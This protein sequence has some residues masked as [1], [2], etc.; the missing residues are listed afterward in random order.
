MSGVDAMARR[1]FR[2]HPFAS[3]EFPFD[4]A[5]RGY[6]V[7]TTILQAALPAH[8]GPIAVVPVEMGDAGLDGR[9]GI[10]AKSIV[11]EQLRAAL[12]IM[13]TRGA[14]REVKTGRLTA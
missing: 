8:D 14:P 12:R 5:R 6:S 9:D 13:R 1:C 2:K 4:V 11:L 10:E 7:G 3:P